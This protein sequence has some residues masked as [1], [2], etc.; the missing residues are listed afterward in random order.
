MF[1]KSTSKVKAPFTTTNVQDVII[2]FKQLVIDRNIS[3][4]LNIM[5]L[6]VVGV[7]KFIKI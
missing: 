2:D 3:K 1:W 4:L 7:L 5:A 6:G